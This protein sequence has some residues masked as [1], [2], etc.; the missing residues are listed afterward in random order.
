MNPK[1]VQIDEERHHLCHPGFLRKT[2]NISMGKVCRDCGGEIMPAGSGHPRI[3]VEI[4]ET[5]RKEGWWPTAL[6]HQESFS[7]QVPAA[8]PALPLFKG[9][10]GRGRVPSR[11]QSGL[12]RSR[13][14]PVSLGRAL[15]SSTSWET[16]RV[17]A[18]R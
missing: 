13:P 18:A 3:W 8:P 5:A 11:G 4:L 17:L 10:Q 6:S 7:C 14:C 16:S 15:D 2:G 9:L 12:A 1:G